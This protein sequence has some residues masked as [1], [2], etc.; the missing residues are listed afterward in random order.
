MDN[1]QPPVSWKKDELRLGILQVLSAAEGRKPSLLVSPSML[2]D[3]LNPIM[4]QMQ[5]A[6][7]WLREQNFV[8]VS[9][10]KFA[11]TEAGKD[12]LIDGLG[13][14]QMPPTDPSRL[15][16]GPVPKTGGSSIALPAPKP[17]PDETS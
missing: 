15:P 17:E 1:T 8:E 2:F 6:L 10:A 4:F 13:P 7:F 14:G 16:R 11:I 5:D 3:C 12:Y 9:D